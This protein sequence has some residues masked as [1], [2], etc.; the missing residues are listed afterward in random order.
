MKA[1]KKPIEIEYYPCHK[2]FLYEI[3]Q[4]S[5]KDRPIYEWSPVLWDNSW[6]LILNIETLEWCYVA[7]EKDMIIKWINWEVYPCKKEIFKKTYDLI[8]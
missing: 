5:T 2:D 6:Q 1:I 7:T 4:W 8:P 3:M